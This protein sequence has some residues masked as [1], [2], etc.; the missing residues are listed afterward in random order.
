[1]IPDFTFPDLDLLE[2]KNMS[3]IDETYAFVQ[4]H[5]SAARTIGYCR[6]FKYKNKPTERCK[7]FNFCE[8]C[9]EICYC[10]DLIRALVEHSVTCVGLH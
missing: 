8:I 10:D 2:V 4:T 5:M 9:K 3:S 6:R 7:F 1:M